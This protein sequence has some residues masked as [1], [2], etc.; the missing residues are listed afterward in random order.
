MM[1]CACVCCIL[2]VHSMICVGMYNMICM[3]MSMCVAYCVCVCVCV[4]VSE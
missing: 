3:C 2:C 1:M 4:C